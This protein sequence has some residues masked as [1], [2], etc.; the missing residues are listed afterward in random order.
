MVAAAS[1]S[2]RVVIFTLHPFEVIVVDVCTLVSGTEAGTPGLAI[3][4]EWRSAR[5]RRQ[6]TQT[7]IDCRTLAEALSVPPYINLGIKPIVPSPRS[8]HDRGAMK[9]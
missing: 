9:P 8:E 7:K 1:I 5:K 6:P 4:L 3:E 2:V